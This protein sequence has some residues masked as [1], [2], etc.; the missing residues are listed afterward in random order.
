MPL[1]P[2]ESGPEGEPL[3]ASLLSSSVGARGEIRL[4]GGGRS[5]GRL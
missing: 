5:K 2:S 4:T 3:A 1:G